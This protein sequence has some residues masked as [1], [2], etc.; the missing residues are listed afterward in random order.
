MPEDMIDA[1]P[2]YDAAEP[3]PFAKDRVMARVK[4]DTVNYFIAGPSREPSA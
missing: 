1:P 4:K 3:P 2:I